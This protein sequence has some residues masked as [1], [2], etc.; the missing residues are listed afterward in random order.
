ME[1]PVEV[2]EQTEAECPEAQCHS[3]V[4]AHKGYNTVSLRL[5][6]H[7]LTNNQMHANKQKPVGGLTNNC[8]L[9]S[10]HPQVG[11]SSQR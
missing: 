9:V 6:V 7:S 8:A 11:L 3:L 1:V 2:A 10:N 5:H 4:K